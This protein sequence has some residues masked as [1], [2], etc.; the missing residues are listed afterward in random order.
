MTE[1]NVYTLAEIIPASIAGKKDQ[2]LVWHCPKCTK[3]FV[4]ILSQKA[5]AI[6]SN[7]IEVK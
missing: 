3:Y 6:C 5:P 7:C 2:I 4:Q 1:K